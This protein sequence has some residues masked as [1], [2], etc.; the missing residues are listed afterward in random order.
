MSRSRRRIP[1]EKDSTRGAKRRANKCV[2]H[3]A[4][5]PNGGGFK[6]VYES[7]MISDYKYRAKT[8]AERVQILRK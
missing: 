7:W 6:R 4:I 5:V 2:R 3:A 1:V 8:E